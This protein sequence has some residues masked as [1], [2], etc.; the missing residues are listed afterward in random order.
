[1]NGS[2]DTSRVVLADFGQWV[3]T[4]FGL[5]CTTGHYTIAK[6]R[7]PKTDLLPYMQTKHWVNGWSFTQALD[8]ARE[9]FSAPGQR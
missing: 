3:V 5:E 9:Y 8:F 1:M 7:L 6:H 4:P 2:N